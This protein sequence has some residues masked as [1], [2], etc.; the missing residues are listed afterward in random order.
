MAGPLTGIGPQQQL[1]ISNTFQP[2]QGATQQQQVRESEDQQPRQNVVQPQGS[3]AAA[4]TQRADSDNTDVGQRELGVS[5]ASNEDE[6][7]NTGG[8]GSLIDISV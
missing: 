7:S 1:P 6:S 5:L 3:A 2:G 8:R 4:E